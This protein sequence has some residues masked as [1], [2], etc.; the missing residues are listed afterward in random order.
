MVK[1]FVNSSQ[2]YP[3]TIPTNSQ[4]FQSIQPPIETFK[5][6]NIGY[7]LTSWNVSRRILS[8][9]KRM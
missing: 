5:L 6:V 1:M 2:K 8:R 9:S 4:Q 3:S 7:F